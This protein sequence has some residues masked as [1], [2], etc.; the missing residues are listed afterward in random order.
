MRL[1]YDCKLTNRVHKTDA[2]YLKTEPRC[3]VDCELY[4]REPTLV[5]LHCQMRP[6]GQRTAKLSSVKRAW[7]VP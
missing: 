2:I 1:Q 6:R 4:L 3:T 7:V 5:L